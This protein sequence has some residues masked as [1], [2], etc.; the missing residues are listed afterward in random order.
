M[1]AF[2]LYLPERHGFSRWT[3][4]GVAILAAHVAVIAS[5]AL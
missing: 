2:A 4:A 5:L 3:L 1:N